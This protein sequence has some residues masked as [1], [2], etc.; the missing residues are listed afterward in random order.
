MAFGAVLVLTAL[1]VTGTKLSA[2][3][4]AV[5]VTAKVA[6]IVFVIAVGSRYLDVD[7]YEPFVPEHEATE[8]GGGKT[9]LEVV[10]GS[11]GSFGFLG[12]FSAAAVIAF[13]YIGFDLIATAAEDAHEPRRSIPRS[14]FIS[15]GIVTVLYL[16]MATVLVGIRPYTELGTRAPV[17]DALAAA[18]AGLDGRHRQRRRRAGADHGDHGGA[19]R[20]E[21]RAVRDG[22]RRPPPDDPSAG[23]AGLLGAEQRRSSLPAARPPCS[24]CGRAW[25]TSSSCWSSAPCRRSC[26]ARSRSSCYAAAVPTSNAASG[27]RWSRSSPPSRSWRRSG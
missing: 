23:S 8:S 26:S 12:V 7:N 5:V 24:R 10:L 25:S 20:P 16:A 4:L 19:D 21:P 9:V 11:A 13:A 3:V 2:R 6:V 14:I 15:L 18:G 27:P 1:V 17:S 22:T